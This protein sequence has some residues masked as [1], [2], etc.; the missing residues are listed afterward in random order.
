MKSSTRVLY[1]VGAAAAL[2]LATPA[3]AGATQQ[4][5]GLYGDLGK[6]DSQYEAL[7]SDGGGEGTPAAYKGPPL[8]K[9]QLTLGAC[10]NAHGHA[11]VSVLT[12]Y[13]RAGT[14]N[15]VFATLRCLDD[16]APATT[17]GDIVKLAQATLKPVSPVIESD[18]HHSLLTGAETHFSIS[19]PL[20]ADAEA[21]QDGLAVA[22]HAKA[23]DFLWDFGDGTISRDEA[24]VHVFETVPADHQVHV[25]LTLTWEG[26][27]SFDTQRISLP[28]TTTIGQFDR[29]IEQV[30]AQLDL[31]NL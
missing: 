31:N 19:S 30:Y 13:T 17:N 6:G 8:D 25:R 24:P 22:L 5:A 2:S 4:Q 7:Y 1:T 10:I 26:Q 21:T 15:E 20:T 28:D 12:I 3:I 16:P 11:A 9:H 29:P 18:F 23:V 27:A 14:N